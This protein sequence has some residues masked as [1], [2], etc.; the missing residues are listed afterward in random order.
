[1]EMVCN[2]EIKHIVYKELAY[3]LI[4]L[5][6]LKDMSCKKKLKERPMLMLK[7][8]KYGIKSLEKEM[9]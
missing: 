2:E 7:E 1:M 5:F 3:L 8:V 4:T 6:L 9:Q